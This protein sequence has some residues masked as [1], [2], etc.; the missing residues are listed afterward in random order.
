[1]LLATM[2]PLSPEQRGDAEREDI[3]AGLNDWIRTSR[4]PVLDFDAAVR[5]DTTPRALNP[6]YAAPDHTH[7]NIAGERLLGQVAAAAIEQALS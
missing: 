7:P 6:A 5:D 4:Y 2:T 1:V 3:R